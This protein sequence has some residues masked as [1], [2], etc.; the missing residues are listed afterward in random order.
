MTAREYRRMCKK[1]VS[2]YTQLGTF[3]CL[4]VFFFFVEVVGI[5]HFFVQ[6]AGWATI[7]TFAPELIKRAFEKFYHIKHDTINKE[8]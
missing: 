3:F 1:K 2:T 7:G 6:S 5:T 8:Y 4:M